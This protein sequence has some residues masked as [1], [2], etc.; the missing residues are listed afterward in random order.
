MTIDEDPSGA[1]QLYNPDDPGAA[2]EW[3]VNVTENDTRNMAPHEVAYEFMQGNLD[4]QET[5]VWREGMGDW[6]PL[7]DCA[8]L[9]AVIA[10]YQQAGGSAAAAAEAQGLD[11]TV[12]IDGAQDSGGG[13]AAPMADPFAAGDPGPG[14]PNPSVD[15]APGAPTPSQPPGAR[16]TG[17]RNEASALF[18]VEDILGASASVAQTRSKPKPREKSESL[19]DLFSLGGGGGIAGAFAPPPMNAP[20]PPPPPEPEPEPEPIAASA[21][22]ASLAAAQLA[23][24]PPRSKR[25]LFIGIGAGVVVL[26]G[27]IIAFAVA[28]GDEE[29]VAQNTTSADT[30]S[31]ATDSPGGETKED[32]DKDSDDDKKDDGDDKDDDKDDDDKKDGDDKKDDDKKTSTGSTGTTGTTKKTDSKTDDKKDDKKDEPK[33]DEKKEEKKETKAAGEFNVNAARSAL[34]SAAGAASGC[35]KKKGKKRKSRATVTF[36]PS[37]R[38]TSVQISGGAAGTSAGSCAA[39]IV[40]GASIPPFTGSAQTVA[41]TFYVKL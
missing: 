12:M 32:P 17:E 40:R 6:I 39:N 8:E 31:P 41:K 24:P 2:G 5:Y 13:V 11:S 26:L 7:D 1:T 34:G 35:G 25:G 38:V 19:D 37:G 18:S 27:F 23:E 33:A 30:S 28:G 22:P 14:A 36:A 21:L 10:Q 9:Q 20:A 4:G 16:M 3:S 15:S 29:T